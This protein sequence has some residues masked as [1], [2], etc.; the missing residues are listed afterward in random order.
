LLLIIHSLNVTN[1]FKKH[2][3]NSVGTSAFLHTHIVNQTAFIVL[4][5]TIVTKL[6]FIRIKTELAYIGDEE[7]HNN[8]D[9]K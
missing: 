9:V 3:H 5:P 6:Q 2:F 4:N 1:V 8:D 7:V